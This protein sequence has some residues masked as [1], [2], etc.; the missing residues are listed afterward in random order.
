MENLLIKVVYHGII[1]RCKWE[2]HISFVILHYKTLGDT[3]NCI[4]SIKK[5]QTSG[6]I[7]IIVV[8]NASNNGSYE[9]LQNKYANEKSVHFIHN[10][11]NLGFA[12]GNNVGFT[13]AK[14]LGANYIAVLNNDIVVS[15]INI[16]EAAEK[17]FEKY[18]FSIMGPDIISLVDHGHQNPTEIT[19]TD[20]GIIKKEIS[21]YRVL[22]ILN[23]LYIY[24]FL[25]KYFGKYEKEN[26][27]KTKQN[28]HKENVQLH[29]SFVLYSP[30]YI[31]YE[32]YAFCPET[33]L[34]M[35]EPI[36]FQYCMKKGY[37]TLY[38]PDI[39]V[40]HKEDSSTNSIYIA[41][42][43]KREFI[44]KNQIKSLEIYIKY[45]KKFK[46]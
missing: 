15:T 36:L 44:F 45:L 25:K 4:E 11:K 13:Y 27:V 21:R 46:S 40:Y 43:S 1:E 22:K 12:N 42:R 23:R 6:D 19:T 31:Q 34:Y 8:D 10:S 2:M 7:D 29:G 39:T 33:F 20:L 3:I 9:T 18:H 35:E 38:C 32:D 14:K 30:L 26:N 41:N 5:T 16:I 28:E 17:C 24:D 37:K